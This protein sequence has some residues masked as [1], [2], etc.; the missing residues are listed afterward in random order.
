MRRVKGRLCRNRKGQFTRCH[1]KASSGGRGRSRRCRYGVNKRTGRC[2][3]TK[4][5]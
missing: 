5:H 1:G 3:K 4:R 2:L